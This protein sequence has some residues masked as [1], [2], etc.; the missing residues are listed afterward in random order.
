MTD[1][2]DKRRRALEEAFFNKYNDE[3]VAK[4]RE[5]EVAAKEKRDLAEATGIQDEKVLDD[6][7]NLGVRATTLAALAIAPLVLLAW[8]DGRLDK[9]ERGAIL[10]AAEEQKMDRTSYGYQLLEKW[11]ESR[12]GD[13]LVA[14]WKGYVGALRSHLPEPAFAALRKDILTRTRAVAEASGGF[15]GL[16]RVSQ[17]EKELLRRI[18]EALS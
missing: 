14:A 16:K 6:L 9:H 18:E 3:L 17:E 4:L 12:P 7:R 15:L 2:L 1:E 13:E 8:R 10:R 5:K 11:L